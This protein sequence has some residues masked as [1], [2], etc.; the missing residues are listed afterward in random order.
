MALSERVL[1]FGGAAVAGNDRSVGIPLSRPKEIDRPD[2]TNDRGYSALRFFYPFR[3]RG[4]GRRVKPIDGGDGRGPGSFQ[5]TV[6]RLHDGGGGGKG[7][8]EAYQRDHA[9]DHE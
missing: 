7:V 4:T 5:E 8:S 6:E 3:R 1:L 2:G 9:R